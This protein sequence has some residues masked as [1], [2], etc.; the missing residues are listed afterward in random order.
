M[1]IIANNPMAKTI[2][3]KKNEAETKLK[4]FDKC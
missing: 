3:P 2:L 4:Y 1:E